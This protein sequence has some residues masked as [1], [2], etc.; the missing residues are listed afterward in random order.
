[1]KKIVDVVKHAIANEVRAKVFYDK[2]S[3]LT[4]DG[5]S[6]MVFLELTEMEN[7]HAQLLV[8]RF[9]ATLKREGVDAAAHLAALE[10]DTERTLGVEGTDLITRGEMRAVIEFAI[11]MEAKARDSYLALR[12]QLND[13]ALKALCDDL[14][15]QEQQHFDLLS[16]LRVNVDTPIDERPAL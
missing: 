12:E 5:E 9:G 11:G 3:Q 10:A 4:Q 16:D 13:A 8:D 6:Q 14:A 7:G 2:A 1:M 15:Q